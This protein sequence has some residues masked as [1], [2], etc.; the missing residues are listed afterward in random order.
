MNKELFVSSTPHETKVGLVE[1]DLL[2]EIYL[3]RENEYTLAGSIYKG[4]V[5]RV[6]PG[7][8]S[9][10]VD[11]GLERDAFLYVSDFM[12]LEEHDDDLTDV[13]PANRGVQDL[14]QQPAPYVEPQHATDHTEDRAMATAGEGDA[15]PE[16]SQEFT[17]TEATDDAQ[18]PVSAAAPELGNAAD[19]SRDR[20]GF[21]G[22]RRRRGGRRDG[23]DRGPERSS[24]R[25]SDRG[26]D[27]SSDRGPER[28]ARPAAESTPSRPQEFT[29]TQPSG[30][31]P[32]YTP[33]V[34]PGES[35]SKYRGYTPPP[36]APA[37]V[38]E[39][40][41]ET[42]YE[43]PPELAA[44]VAA[45]FPEDEPIFAETESVAEPLHEEHEDIQAVH[46]EHAESASTSTDW[47]QEFRRP[48]TNDV[49]S[50]GWP[51]EAI[52]AIEEEAERESMVEFPRGSSQGSSQGV[53]EE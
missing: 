42:S 48:E 25:S 11:I 45:T 31:P 46:E 32:G 20:G 40:A 34:L 43:P 15:Q 33:M 49:P 37:P 2:A 47:N 26:P 36:P 7:M 44:P 30:P 27:R 28:F 19:Q 38:H 29:R 1:D 13:V 23:R 52:V 53:V 12:E 16:S 21:R 4:R 24:D 8:Q 35:I 18:P 5:T 17:E 9:A 41:R 39:A 10:F 22:R 50:L 3:E 6:L 14:R 51:G